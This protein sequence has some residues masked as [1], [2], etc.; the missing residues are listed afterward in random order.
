MNVNIF[1]SVKKKNLIPHTKG[2]A[3]CFLLYEI[4]GGIDSSKG[5]SK[6]MMKVKFFE[7]FFLGTKCPH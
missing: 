3:L 2:T 4:Q 5:F 1:E 7:E 6:C